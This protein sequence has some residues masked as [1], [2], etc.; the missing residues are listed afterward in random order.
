MSPESLVPV[1]S[2]HGEAKSKHGTDE[3]AWIIGVRLDT[4]TETEGIPKPLLSA[5]GIVRFVLFDKADS[6]KHGLSFGNVLHEKT[7]EKLKNY[8]R[9]GWHVAFN[10]TELGR[11]LQPI[12]C[13]VSEPK[14]P[15]ACRGRLTA[16]ELKPNTIPPSDATA[17]GFVAC[18]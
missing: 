6:L 12:K 5:N 16:L 1:E 14:A 2:K 17:L 8:K 11:R 9:N 4:P 3:G 15:I 13:L 10:H 7:I 18:D